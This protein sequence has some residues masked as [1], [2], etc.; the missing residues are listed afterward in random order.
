MS[1]GIVAIGVSLCFLDPILIALGATGTILPYA[2]QFAV[3]YII[4]S[5]FNIF[6]VT[7]N[8]IMTSEGMAKFTM[9]SMLTSGVLNI[10]LNPIF[11]FLL[12]LG[13][14][15]SAFSTVVSQGVASQY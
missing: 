5:V 12:G 13:I 8:N 4:G 10:I 6:C 7:M 15:G 3:I 2:R 11:I 14:R 1:V 9:V